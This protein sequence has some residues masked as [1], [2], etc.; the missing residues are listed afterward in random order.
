[1]PSNYYP[2]VVKELKNCGF[3]KVR[4]GKGSH[5]IWKNPIR[6]KTVSVPRNL[7]RRHTANGIL[8]VA[9]SSIKL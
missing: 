3:E 2:S 7:K 6:N 8:R 4:Q 1:M 9:D 5:E